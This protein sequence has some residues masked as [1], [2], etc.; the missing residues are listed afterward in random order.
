MIPIITQDQQLQLM[1]SDI[2]VCIWLLVA[3]LAFLIVKEAMRIAPG[4]FKWLDKKRAE[5]EATEKEEKPKQPSV[6]DQVAEE[7]EKKEQ[8]KLIE[9]DSSN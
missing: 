1:H 2:Q 7:V 3:I 5:V 4:F 9:N 8:R 6:L